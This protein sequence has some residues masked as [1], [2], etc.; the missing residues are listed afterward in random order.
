[1]TPT[2][3]KELRVALAYAVHVL[4]RRI[5]STVRLK[6]AASKIEKW[7]RLHAKLGGEATSEREGPFG[8]QIAS[9]A[10]EMRRTRADV[11]KIELELVERI[12]ALEER[13]QNGCDRTQAGYRAPPLPFE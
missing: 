9:L 12:E 11:R 10:R 1:L 4:E 6:D 2:E 3:K 8:E 5:D 7:E 13:T